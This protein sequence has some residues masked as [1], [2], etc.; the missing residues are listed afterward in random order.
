MADASDTAMIR[1][2]DPLIRIGH[3]V[4]VAAFATAYL[5]EG[6][7]QWLHSF[8]GYAIAV[9]VAIRILWG[10]VGPRRA[11]FSD[12]VTGPGRVLTYLRDLI[13]GRAERHVG[14]SPAGGAMTVALLFALALTALSG[15]ANLAV[16]EGKGPL[17]G[18]V[19]AQSLPAWMA[20]EDDDD[21][22]ISGGHG[23]GGEAFEE[24]HEFAANATLLLV[25][26]HL[27]GVLWASR[28]HG[29]NLARSMITGLKRRAE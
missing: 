5:T 25:F 23:E 19:T 14:H 17:A 11:R 20:E 22:Y 21:D 18:I 13:S 27:A 8:A 3:W 2:W 9:T 28:A 26:L 12:F 24:I 16:E 15:M 10:F 4:L 7:P 29:E 1:V 6:E